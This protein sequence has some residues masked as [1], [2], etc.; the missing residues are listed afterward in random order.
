[1]RDE[2]GARQPSYSSADTDFLILIG[3]II[4]GWGKI[5]RIVSIAIR[6]KQNLAPQHFRNGKVPAGFKEKIKALRAICKAKTEFASNLT[7]INSRLEELLTLAQDRHTIIYGM[8]H[9]I[10]GEPEPQIYFRRAPPLSGE[11]GDR[12]LAT[13]AKLETYI[14]QMQAAEYEMGLLMIALTSTPSTS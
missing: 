8:F 6:G 1:M 10:S 2:L 11:P 14:K 7:R 12:L 3:R 9:G 4:I 5:E 13:R